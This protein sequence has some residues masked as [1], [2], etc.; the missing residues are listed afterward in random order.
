MSQRTE[1]IYERPNY[2]V[3]WQNGI[4]MDYAYCGE[5]LAWQYANEGYVVERIR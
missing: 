2:R 3:L 5:T 4:F 1:I